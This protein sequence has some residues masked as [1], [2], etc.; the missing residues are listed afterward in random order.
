MERA[1]NNK[2]SMTKTYPGC[3]AGPL[4][5][6]NF[7]KAHISQNAPPYCWQHWMVG[8]HSST[9]ERKGIKLML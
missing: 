2:S 8:I 9:W 4:L 6:A 1:N 7:C 3:L 5:E